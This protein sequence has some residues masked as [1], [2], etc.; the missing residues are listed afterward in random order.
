VEEEEEC[1]RKR[2]IALEMMKLV[3]VAKHRV[4]TLL[5]EVTAARED[6]ADTNLAAQKN[7]VTVRYLPKETRIG[8]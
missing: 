8:I 6:V 2:P 1:G 5:N 3:W 7:N 4:E